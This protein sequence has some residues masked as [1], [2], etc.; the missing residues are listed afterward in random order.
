VAADLDVLVA[1]GLDMERQQA[2]S[3][4]LRKTFPCGDLT[5]FL[6][7]YNSFAIDS[8]ILRHAGIDG[9]LPGSPLTVNLTVKLRL[10]PLRD[11]AYKT[12]CMD[13]AREDDVDESNHFKRA[14]AP[15]P[16]A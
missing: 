13:S 7:T 16:A 3:P 6:L 4:L 2:R 15:L 10:C 14:S 1:R 8:V 5:L 11:A 9:S 12:T